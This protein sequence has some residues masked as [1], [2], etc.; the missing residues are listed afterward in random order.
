MVQ[1]PLAL[2]FSRRKWGLLPRIENGDFS[3]SAK[4]NYTRL[5]LWIDADVGVQGSPDHVFVKLYTHGCQEQNAG[6]LLNGGLRDL[7]KELE[8]FSY[9]EDM[10]VHFVTARELVNVVKSIEADVELTDL[11]AAKNFRYIRN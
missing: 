10:A 1:G 7:Y 2:N 5:H 8:R 3:C 6:Y 9:Q 11:I 4:F